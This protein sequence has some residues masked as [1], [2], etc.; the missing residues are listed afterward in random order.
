[1]ADINECW[2]PTKALMSEIL[3]K[4]WFVAIVMPDSGAENHRSN[5]PQNTLVV[6][7][8]S[9]T[10]LVAEFRTYRSTQMCVR[11]CIVRDMSRF[12]PVFYPEDTAR[13]S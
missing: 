4:N 8:F 7:G 10:W 6:C 3:F 9:I 5:F 2:T 13:R 11:V 1:M 12:Y